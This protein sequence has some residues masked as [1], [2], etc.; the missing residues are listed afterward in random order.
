MAFETASCELLGSARAPS[1]CVGGHKVHL[2]FFYCQRACGPART[3]ARPLL[4]YAVSKYC[5]ANLDDY[6]F[7]EEFSSWEEAVCVPP[8]GVS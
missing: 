7:R 4:A 8:P 6:Q 5:I 2:P 3:A 1:T